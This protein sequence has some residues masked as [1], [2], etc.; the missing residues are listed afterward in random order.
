MILA[1]KLYQL[2]TKSGLSQE[3]L[4]QK[5]NVSRQSISKWESANSIPSMDKIVQLSE[6]YGV[7][8]DYL[9]KEDME[10][11]PGE[12]VADL[13]GK[14]HTRE[15]TV[16]EI[17]DYQR[18]ATKSKNKYALGVMLCIWSVVPLLILLSI[19]AAS[20]GMLQEDT[21]SVIGTVILLVIVA[22]ATGIFILTGSGLH[23]YDYLNE[24][25]FTL[26]YGAEDIL[27]KEMEELQP[28]Y[29]K[30]IAAGVI[31]CI[32][33]VV[34]LILSAAFGAGE[35]YV[36]GG[37]VILL[38]LVGIAVFLFVSSGLEMDIYR[39]LLQIGDYTPAQKK[40]E[41]KLSV[42][43]SAYWLVITAVFLLW[44]FLTNDWDITWV[45]WPVGSIL[46]AA[47]YAILSAVAGRNNQ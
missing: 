3:E 37:V 41:K 24:E 47:I 40:I 11:V 27:K 12:V 32:I 16:E 14:S 10:E 1:E 45:I 35:E 23:K 33:S 26:E 13:S 44:S 36:Y 29:H 38:M 39:K 7:S 8:T 5:L 28:S 22:A 31:L 6:I 42:F 4:A 46:Y 21:A 34:P 25:D 20:D 18:L 30:N 9:L 2:R 17:R 43:S 19:S 15:V